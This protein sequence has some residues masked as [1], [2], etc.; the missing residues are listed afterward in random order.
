MKL[1][2]LD[3]DGVLNV[4]RADSVTHPEQLVLLP[5]AAEAVA[6]LNRAGFKI[7]VVS[8]QSCVGRGMATLEILALIHVKLLRELRLHDAVIDDI[9]VC[10]DTAD[11]PSYRRKPKPGMLLEAMKKY[12][13]RPEETPM[14]GDDLRDL[15]AAKAAACPRYLVRTGKGNMVLSSPLPDELQPV[16]IC[17]DLYG[18]ARSILARFG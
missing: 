14:I 7:A 9:F 5:R 17:D 3:R 16:E 12:D 8:N 6:M 2:L 4:D 18:A 1:V 10:T 13:A 15:Q 11:I